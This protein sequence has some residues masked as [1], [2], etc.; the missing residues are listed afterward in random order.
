M[1][2]KYDK[3]KNDARKLGKVAYSLSP[4]PASRAFFAIVFTITI[5]EMAHKNKSSTKEK[6]SLLSSLEL[7]HSLDLFSENC[8]SW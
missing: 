4:Q 3:R 7:R 8:R 1:S 6:S 5:L 2:R